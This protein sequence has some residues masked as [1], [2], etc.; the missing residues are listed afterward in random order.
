MF[1]KLASVVQDPK[2]RSV[3]ATA[4]GMLLFLGGRKVAG[5][6]LFA[7]GL[8][9]LEASWRAAHPDV[10]GFGARWS[11][12]IRFYEQTHGNPVNRA[13]HMVGIPIIVGGTVGMIAAPSY[14]PPWW[15]AAGAFTFGWTLNFVGHGVFEKNAPAFADDPLSFVAGPIWDLQ[16][17]KGTL[18]SLANGRT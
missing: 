4:G 2:T 9:G 18:A 15:V 14:S 6:G 10:Q 5:L 8:S 1:G 17:L 3:A 11:E 12:A 7:S 16:Q 13:L